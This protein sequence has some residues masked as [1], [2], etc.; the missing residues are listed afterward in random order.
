MPNLNELLN[1]PQ[2]WRST[3]RNLAA[4]GNSVSSG[5]REL[6]FALHSGGWPVAGST[7]VLCDRSGLGEITLLLPAL[8]RLSKQQTL[9]WVNPPFTPYGPALQQAGV[10]LDN[11]LFIHTHK[12]TD[13]LWACEEL[14][15]SAT[16]AAVLNWTGTQRLNDRDLRRL[17]LA[18]RDQ[19]C[20]HLHFRA[21]SFRHQSSP[22]PLRLVLAA[23]TEQLHVELLK[24]SGGP[25]GQQIALTRDAFLLHRQQSPEQWPVPRRSVAHKRSL[26][27]TRLRLAHRGHRRQPGPRLLELR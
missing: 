18:A 4:G 12:L 25:A 10:V 3:R 21:E 22:A 27:K 16:C 6:D 24:Q 1:N 7:E 20:W 17:Q 5:H 9:A 23:S 26:Q 2:L 19:N 8:A 14:L 11:C 13:H 15:R